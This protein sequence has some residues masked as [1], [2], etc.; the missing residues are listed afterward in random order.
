MSSIVFLPV[1]LKRSSLF[2]QKLGKR[3]KS[4]H[5]S[6]QSPRKEVR[7][8]RVLKQPDSPSSKENPLLAAAARAEEINLLPTLQSPGWGITT[9]A[10]RWKQILTLRG[11]TLSTAVPAVVLS[12][13]PRLSQGRGRL[14]LIRGRTS[15]LSS[16]HEHCVQ[17]Q[18]I[19]QIQESQ[20]GIWL[21]L[22]NKFIIFRIGSALDCLRGIGGVL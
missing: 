17:K 4:L 13:H 18:L 16:V 19:N 11:R 12:R 22:T 8:T 7:Q 21:H 9:E 10:V 14:W 15:W 2:V 5:L 3:R 20:K 6:S 1:S